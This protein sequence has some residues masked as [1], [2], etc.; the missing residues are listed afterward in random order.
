MHPALLL[1]LTL[2]KTT[3]LRLLRCD[4]D[5]SGEAVVDAL[6]QT[7]ETPERLWNR[8]MYQ[9][10][11]EEVA[12][13]AAAARAAQVRCAAQVPAGPLSERLESTLPACLQGWGVKRQLFCRCCPGRP[14]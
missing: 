1:K 5:G 13:L 3:L 6:G 14:G 9:A 11:A 2:L 4:Q 10:A 12:H 8:S 7:S